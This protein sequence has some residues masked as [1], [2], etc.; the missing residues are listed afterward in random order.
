MLAYNKATLYGGSLVDYLWIKNNVDTQATIDST[1]NYYYSPVWEGETILLAPFTE[2]INGGN[3]VSLSDEVVYW[4]IYR[5]TPDSNVLEFVTKVPAFQSRLLDYGVSNNKSYSYTIFA[6]TENYISAPMPMVN[7]ITTNW[8]TWSIVDLTESETTGLYYVQGNTWIFNSN[9]ESGSFMQNIDKY[10]F[11]TFTQFP[12]TS[13]GKRNYITTNVSALLGNIDPQTGDY[14]NDTSELM[15]SFK[16]FIADG[17][18]KLL[19]DR[20]GN[21]FICETTSN[22]FDI[23][24]NSVEQVTT[25]N[26][27]VTQV[28][29]LQDVSIIGA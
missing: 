25:V 22:A 21:A 24:D 14:I 9:L 16:E 28:N 27:D 20:K 4:Q 2:N 3:I 13:S 18:L 15:D 29:S 12:K 19:K 5:T 8:N 7:Y 6:E 26:F 10:I 1:S 17:S 11:E 23:V